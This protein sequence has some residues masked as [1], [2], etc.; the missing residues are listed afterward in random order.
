MIL[1]R[2]RSRILLQYPEKIS[3]EPISQAQHQGQDMKEAYEV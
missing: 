1:A 3:Q 2:F